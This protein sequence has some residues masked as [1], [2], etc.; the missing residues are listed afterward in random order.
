[1]EAMQLVDK[2]G[3]SARLKS[4]S[5]LPDERVVLDD[6]TADCRVVWF[7]EADFKTRKSDVR[8]EETVWMELG[9]TSS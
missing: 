4:A 8:I 7:T 2:F 1:M 5:F 3:C 9:G 6:C